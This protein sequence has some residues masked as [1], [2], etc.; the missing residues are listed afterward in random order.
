M[1]LWL[2][3]ALK[4]HPTSAG[5]LFAKTF[6]RYQPRHSRDEGCKWLNVTVGK[7]E[8]TSWLVKIKSKVDT[9]PTSNKSENF[10]LWGTTNSRAS[11]GLHVVRQNGE[12]KIDS[13][14]PHFRRYRWYSKLH[15]RWIPSRVG[16]NATRWPFQT[17]W[18]SSKFIVRYENRKRKVRGSGLSGSVRCD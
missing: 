11:N 12:S 13:L 10:N 18:S 9:K 14:R 3:N 16:K 4:D 5:L 8:S 6:W 17:N 1:S 15:R 2:I 7:P